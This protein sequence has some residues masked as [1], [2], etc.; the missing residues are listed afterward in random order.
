M[1]TRGALR[2]WPSP[3]HFHLHLGDL[4]KALLASLMPI[5][6]F[7][8]HFVQYVADPNM[9]LKIN[10][11]FLGVDNQMER[12]KFCHW[13]KREN[14]KSVKRKIENYVNKTM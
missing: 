12:E 11:E 6:K 7:K 10:D 5:K 2:S 13:K 14:L 1:I 8:R 4:E 3:L 9:Q